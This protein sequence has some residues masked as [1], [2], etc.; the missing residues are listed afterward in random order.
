MNNKSM[1]MNNFLL[2]KLLKLF[3]IALEKQELNLKNQVMIH[4]KNIL[5]SNQDGSINDFLEIRRPFVAPNP[6]TVSS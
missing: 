3:Y 4:S 1:E 2:K 6:N 5:F